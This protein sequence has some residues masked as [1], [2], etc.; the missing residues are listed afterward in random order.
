MP[1]AKPRS[2]RKP[3]RLDL[4]REMD[5]VADERKA[6]NL[7][8]FFKTGP[9]EYGEGDQFIGLT[10]PISR[11]IALR[12]THLPLTEIS[13]LLASPIHEHRFVAFEILVAQYERADETGRQQIFDYYLHNTHRANNWDLVDT[14]CRYIVGRHLV[15]RPKPHLLLD[16][17]ASSP[18][19]WERRIAI[20]STFAFLANGETKETFRIARKLLNDKEPLIHKAVG[21]LL[22]EAGKVSRAELVKFLE[23]HAAKMPRTTLRY[24]IERFPAEE[25]KQWLSRTR[26][27][28][29]AELQ[30]LRPLAPE[31]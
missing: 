29:N 11:K 17:L 22:R 8:W 2:T 26:T 28:P 3:T 4:L 13:K 5:G 23:K 19:L 9:G 30:S 24:A 21:W 25:R 12:H 7:A 6:R 31:A 14:S 10:V 27:R 15:T 16:E 18:M 20:V 1:S